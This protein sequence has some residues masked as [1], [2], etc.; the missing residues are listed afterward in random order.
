MKIVGFFGFKGAGKDSGAQPLLDSGFTKMAF[1]D[2]IKDMV[3][4][5]FVWERDLMEGN[6]VESRQWRET[7]DVW[8]SEKLGIP[9]FTPR[10]AMTYLGTD[11][12]RRYIHDD[13]WLNS[14]YRK[15]LLRGGDR[16]VLSDIRHRH[17]IK[18]ATDI[19]TINGKG[20]LFIHV[21]KGSLPNHWGVTSTPDFMYSLDLKRDYMEQN[22]PQIHPSEW[23][24]NSFANSS[25]VTIE[26][27][28]T[29]ENLH[30]K[31]ISVA[32]DRSWI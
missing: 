13:I 10:V 11:I 26:N 3:S 4:S 29:I 17:E 9:N 12:M 7:V 30:N 5:I 32:G 24:W 14:L 23:E 22:Y 31:V 8:W 18:F 19:G 20:P 25:A 28:S 21:K 1:A 16:I 27:N 15:M 2:S 6:T